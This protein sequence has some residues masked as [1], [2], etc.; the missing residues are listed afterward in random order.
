MPQKKNLH[1]DV[2]E[3]QPSENEKTMKEK[4][5]NIGCFGWV[6]RA[7]GLM[8]LWELGGCLMP[9]VLLFLAVLLIKMCG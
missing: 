9:F 3:M 6:M 2:G 1:D 8:L 5:E 7:M 4:K